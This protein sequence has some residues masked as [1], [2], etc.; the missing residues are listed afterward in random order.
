MINPTLPFNEALNGLL[1]LTNLLG[2]LQTPEGAAPGTTPM[3]VLTAAGIEMRM[4]E[5]LPLCGEEGTAGGQR[6]PAGEWFRKIEEGL[7]SVRQATAALNAAL[8][9]NVKNIDTTLATHA[10]A[11]ETVRAALTQNEQLMESMVELMG[12]ADFT[13][14][15]PDEFANIS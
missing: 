2:S 15:N 3:I 5:S 1:A 14:P 7:E 9:E 8:S 11:I 6:S 12:P 13:L 10:A 4:A